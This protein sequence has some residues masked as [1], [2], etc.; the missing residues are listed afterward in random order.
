MLILVQ[1]SKIIKGD[2]I[3]TRQPKTTLKNCLI[4]LVLTLV[5]LPHNI[6]SAC[7]SDV[8]MDGYKLENV[9]A[10]YFS[11]DIYPIP[12]TMVI[13]GIKYASTKLSDGV[14]DG[15]YKQCT[16][17]DGNAYY[18]LSGPET[19]AAGA[20]PT[21]STLQAL[22]ATNGRPTPA[23]VDN[24]IGRAVWINSC[25]NWQIVLQG[26]NTNQDRYAEGSITVS[27]VWK[28]HWASGENHHGFPLCKLDYQ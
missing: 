13:D 17:S 3:N 27:T 25:R 24:A 5:V 8:S 1:Y 18:T 28:N 2:K 22:P 6:Q 12:F 23:E 20:C 16:G 26:T 10:I 15:S 4:S 11:G 19:K 21:G 7:S 9:T 14:F